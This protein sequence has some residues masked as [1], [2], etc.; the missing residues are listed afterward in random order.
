M[1]VS[2][3]PVYL[4]IVQ[5]VLMA[6]NQYCVEFSNTSHSINSCRQEFI[7]SSATFYIGFIPIQHFNYDFITNDMNAKVKMRRVYVLLFAMFSPLNCSID[8]HEV[9]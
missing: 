5:N 3:S 1:D 2:S 7:K 9:S 8:Q 4:R 6:C